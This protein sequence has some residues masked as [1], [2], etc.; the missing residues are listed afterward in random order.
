MSI[1]SLLLKLL[2]IKL[3]PSV[4]RKSNSSTVMYVNLFS[5]IVVSGGVEEEKGIEVNPFVP[6]VHYT[7]HT[8]K[9]CFLSLYKCWLQSANEKS[10][11]RSRDFF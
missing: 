8:L 4:E 7:V 2:L 10:S 3:I 11:D 5:R 6:L 1:N 9:L